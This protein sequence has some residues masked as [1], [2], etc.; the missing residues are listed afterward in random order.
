MSEKDKKAEDIKVVGP[1]VGG[2]NHSD[3]ICSPPFFALTVAI[4]PCEVNVYNRDREG[5]RCMG[6]E[7][8]VYLFS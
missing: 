5:Q 7:Q 8:Y 1:I 3:A 4:F 6:K 2:F